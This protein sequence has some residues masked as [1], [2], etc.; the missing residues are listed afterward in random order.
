MINKHSSLI[1]LLLAAI[2]LGGCF[3]KKSTQAVQYTEEEAIPYKIA[4][5]PAEYIKHAENSTEHKSVLVLDDDRLFVAD[6]ARAA[7][8]NQL[9]GKGFMPLQKDVVDNTLAELGRD[10]GWRKMSDV[11]LCKLL[12]AD[13]IVKTD[14]YSADMIKA[15]AFDLF[16]LDAEVM[17]YNAAGTLVGKWR[18]SASKRR[19]SVPTGVIGLAGTIVEEV[20]SDPIRRQMRMVVYDWA[21]NM[22]QVLPD[23]P[24]GPKL[25]EVIAVD[26]NVDNLLFGVGQRVAVRVDAEPGLKC[27]FSIGD[28]KKNIPL[29]Q[30]S[31]G[32]Y[33]GF[34]VVAEGD[35][36]A[37]EPVMVKMRKANGVDRLWIESG[38]LI[39]LDG[40]L[41]PV[42]ETIQFQTGRDGVKLN[43]LVP[44]AA[45]LEEFVVEKGNDPVGEFETIART[46]TPEFVDTDVKQG[47]AVFY[48]VR[49]KDKAGNLSPLNGIHKVIMPQFDER[50]LFGELSGVLVKGNYRIGFPVT[51]SEGSKFTLQSGTKIRFENKGR[52]D[53]FGELES[54]GEISAPVRLES[55]STVGIKVMSGGKAL[56]SQCEFNG[57]SKAVTSA[58]GYT[59]IRSSSFGGGEYAV[60]VTETGHYDFKGLRISGVWKGLVLSAG[61]GSVVRSSITNCTQGIDFKGGSVEIKDNNIFDN[62]RNIVAAGKLVVSDNYFGSASVEKLK[63]AGD[64]LVK[65]ILD[66]PYPH[67]RRVVLIDDKEITPE[68]REKKFAEL[69]ALGVNAFHSQHYGD[70]YQALIQAVKMKDDRDIYL[71]LS[72]TLLA[73]GDDVALSEILDEGISKFPYDVRLHQ[74]NVRYLLNKGDIKQARQVLDKAL[75]LSPADSNLLYMKDYLDHLAVPT[76]SVPIDTDEEKAREDKNK[77]KNDEK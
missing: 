38:S 42:L 67:G 6:I 77:D 18:D 34:Y 74:L 33:E 15:L 57:F 47:T 26:T 39:S 72:Y 7:I 51:V 30:I 10:D 4:V 16:Q 50:E 65:S 27:S 12:N 14:I 19:I 1:F 58:G 3:A 69:K 5:L 52:I 71:Y 56:F 60:A 75:Q 20:F 55:N 11:D 8:T 76:E 29:P 41:P 59:E 43:W 28:F 32:V 31:Q 46:R 45:D 22:A 63:L 23:C 66:A 36:A 48:R 24:K 17:M 25:P 64:I 49:I 2:L 73:L 54:I 70:A 61:N 44:S 53:V 21:W 37:N 13:G 9:A 35:K 62:E 40:V 68:L